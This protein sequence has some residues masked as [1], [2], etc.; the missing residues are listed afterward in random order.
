MSFI[1][2][3]VLAIGAVLLLIATLCVIL[4]TLFPPKDHLGSPCHIL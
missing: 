3:I 4:A 1:V 2:K